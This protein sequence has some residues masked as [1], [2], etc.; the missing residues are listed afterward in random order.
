MN[1]LDVIMAPTEQPAYDFQNTTAV[2]I[3]V[4]R[5]ASC[6]CTALANGCTEII[7]VAEIDDAWQAAEIFPR[8][9]VLLA[10]ERHGRKINGFDLGNSPKEF[11]SAVVAGKTIVM[12]TTNGTRSLLLAQA[13]TR[14]LILSLL[15][16]RSLTNVL[17]N[18]EQDIVL[19]CAGQDKRESL[20]DT[21]CAGLLVERLQDQDEQRWQISE[22]AKSAMAQ[23]RIHKIDLLAMMQTSPHGEYLNK[24]GF[25]DDLEICSRV[26][27]FEVTPIFADGSIRLLTSTTV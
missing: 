14:I 17:R 22:R 7:P 19:V 1:K 25:S 6:I 24:I 11:Q 4:L 23:A 27:A 21:V 16:L 12:T 13:A 15:N 9:L 10:G 3:D 5:A 18:T 20:E 8:P 26:N 2:V